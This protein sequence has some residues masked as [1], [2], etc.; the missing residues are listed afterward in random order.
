MFFLSVLNEH[1]QN[2]LRKLFEQFEFVFSCFYMCHNIALRGEMRSFMFSSMWNENT[3]N[4]EKSKE[5]F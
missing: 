1:M 5:K 4:N 3:S 2:C